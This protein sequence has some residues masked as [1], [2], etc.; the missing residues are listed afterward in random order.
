MACSKFSCDPFIQKVRVNGVDMNMTLDTGANCS[1]ISLS[2][3]KK[4]FENR[5]PLD[6]TV[7]ELK[8]LDETYL[9]VVGKFTVYAIINGIRVNNLTLFVV[10]LPRRSICLMGRDWINYFHNII[11][12]NKFKS[13]YNESKSV[14]VCIKSKHE[15]DKTTHQ[16]AV[17]LIQKQFPNLIKDDFGLIKNFQARIILKPGSPTTFHK[18]Y[19][20]AIALRE[21]VRRQ[22]ETEVQFGILEKVKY[23]DYASPIVAVG[24]KCSAEVRVCGDFKRTINKYIEFEHYPL[25]KFTDLSLNWANCTY[26]SVIDLSKA[27][28]QLS[29]HPDDRKYLTINTHLGLYRYNRL[30][31]GVS[32]AAPA[33]QQCMDQMLDGLP[34]TC[35]YLDDIMVAGRTLSEA[36][37]RLSA[38][39]S[40]LNDHNVRIN[41]NK[42]RFVQCNVEYVGHGISS[43]GI[44]PTREHFEAIQKIKSPTNFS[45]LQKFLGLINYYHQHLHNIA[46]IASPLYSQKKDS[47]LW[48][49][50]EERAFEACKKSFLDSPALIPYDPNKPIF[51]I[52][53]AS[54]FGT[55]AVLYHLDE[56]NRERPVFFTSK[57]LNSAQKKYPHHEKEALALI[58]AVNKFHKYIFGHKFT[59][60]TDNKPI[61]SLLSQEKSVPILAKMRLQRWA[62]ILSAYDYELKYRK[63]SDIILADFL[64]R[65]PLSQT[66]INEFEINHIHQFRDVCLPLNLHEVAI[67]TQTDSVLNQVH[68]ITLKGWP[69]HCPSEALKPYFFKKDLLTVEQ[70]CILVGDR[71][72]IPKV[73]REKVL[74]ILHLGHPG[75]TKSKMLAR[76]LIWWPN[77]EIDIENYL[78]YCVACQSTRNAD[79]TNLYSWPKS[80]RRMQRVHIDFAQFNKKYFLILVDSYSNWL[81]VIPVQSTDFCSIEIALLK[82][83]SNN[84]FC[85]YLISDGGPPFNSQN[86]A[87]FCEKRGIKHILSPAYH[88]QSNGHAEKGVQTFKNFAKKYFLENPNSSS[89]MF[90]KAILDFLFAF[91][92][93]PSIST[94]K[95]PAELFMK[96]KCKTYLTNLNPK[97]NTTSIEKKV[98][99]PKKQFSDGQI[100]YVKV[101]NN[102][103]VNW[104]KGSIIC[105]VSSVIYKVLIN[106][107]Y[108]NVHIDHLRLRYENEV[109]E[110]TTVQ[111]EDTGVMSFPT[112]RVQPQPHTPENV[113]NNNIV[114]HSPPTPQNI[115]NSPPTPV[116]PLHP[117]LQ[118]P[119]VHTLP[120][121]SVR[122]K[123]QPKRLNL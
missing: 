123:C 35:A 84:G 17:N 82:F 85:E 37:N 98:V 113:P 30:I 33:F 65:N 79:P 57:T 21:P 50:I 6:S 69:E 105:Q 15:F 59:L 99:V 26:F 7:D 110:E 22:L 42:S 106:N 61:V 104:Q 32:S 117:V 72:V 19:D 63:G 11:D 16:E 77:I 8:C 109:S 1:L 45:E 101:H 28:L 49:E 36:K 114:Q 94:G 80:I 97:Y 20:L 70:N 27:Y 108:K 86:F 56:N 66:D 4:G 116:S 41:V 111:S 76:T 81:D 47:F 73:L 5:C 75:V 112:P 89:N 52:T 120:R 12:W 10:D 9:N 71:V 91:R 103:F 64:S 118:Q 31:Y 88:A 48:G 13:N 83:F 44:T 107:V 62:V 95:C 38:V 122:L 23:S 90:L 18:P 43:H 67:A 74:S 51:I 121:R 39:L 3:Y 29:V 119:T 34:G 93:T 102:N 115:V 40:R 24:K 58:H 14:N 54:A 78:K 68:E 92:N 53:D 87:D 46:S 25:P 60:Y 96:S 55:S 2:V 100:V